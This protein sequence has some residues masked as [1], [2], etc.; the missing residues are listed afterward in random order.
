[1]L[2]RRLVWCALAAALLVGSLQFAMQRWQAL[3]IILAAERFEDQKAAAPAPAHEHTH[4][5]VHE[6]AAAGGH[7]HAAAEHHHDEAAWSPADGAE[8]GFWT[9]VANVLHS[10]SMAMLLFA[11]MGAWVWRRGGSGG[12][13]RLALAVAAAGWL[14]LHLWPSLGLPAEVPGMDAADLRARQAWWLLAAAGAAGACGMLAFSTARWR[15]IAAAVLLA[16]PFVVRA[17]Q[18]ADPLAGFSGEAHARLAQLGRDFVWATTWVSLSFWAS[19]GV[20]G[21]A[22]FARWLQPVLAEMR[23][24]AASAAPAIGASR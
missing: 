10:F 12:M 24:N 16:L 14:S 8:R 4:E 21:G 3:P 11:V 5:P 6:G 18:V 20:I 22:L 9:W 17:P 7:E 13:A 19:L 23:T 1:M 15:W 2:F